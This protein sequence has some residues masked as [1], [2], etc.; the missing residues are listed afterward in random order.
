MTIDLFFQISW[1][2]LK[3]T[4]FIWAF[5]FVIRNSK[6]ETSTEDIQSFATDRGE[7]HIAFQYKPY[8][9]NSGVDMAM[10]TMDHQMA[11]RR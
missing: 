11:N 7:P 6:A 3:L 9:G 8:T 2:L 4:A 1:T 5:L 10:S